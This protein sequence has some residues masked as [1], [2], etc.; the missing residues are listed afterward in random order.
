VFKE[1]EMRELTF[2]EL[3]FVS[4][5][6]DNVEEIVVTGHYPPPPPIYFPPSYS[7]PSY[8]PG[9]YGGGGSP[10][11]P[12]SVPAAT[13][14]EDK[15]CQDG[16]AVSISDHIKQILADPGTDFEYSCYITRNSDGS[17]GAYKDTIRTN[18]S[19]T[20]SGSGPVDAGDWGNLAGFIHDHPWNASDYWSNYINR[21]PSAQDW[22]PLDAI[23]ANNPGVDRSQLSLY[24]LDPFGTVRE[25]H[26]ADKDMLNNMDDTQ[27]RAGQNLGTE[28][29]PC[30]S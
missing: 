5:G 15:P 24:L 13:H 17:F 10:S 16:A 26:Y 11:V 6:E 30:G 9:Y 2:E 19:T 1:N 23:I 14:T 18:N 3:Q 4:G 22:A 27:R 21:Y 8:P 20:F 7:Y 29:K 25:Y 12:P 28:A